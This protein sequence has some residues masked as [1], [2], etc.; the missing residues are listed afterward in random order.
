ML[1]GEFK[2]ESVLRYRKFQEEKL[3]QEL[4]ETNRELEAEK[5]RLGR[6]ESQLED[7]RRK[8]RMSISKTVS[9]PVLLMHNSFLEQLC[10]KIARQL[11]KVETAERR[12]RQKRDQVME[13]VKKRKCLE[14]VKENFLIQQQALQRRLQGKFL[15]EIG[16]NRYIRRHIDGEDKCNQ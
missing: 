14:K 7:A 12:C 16:V 10:L 6:L 4:S 8:F 15:D 11:E 3:Q 1:M 5:M 2:Y 9:S 13:A